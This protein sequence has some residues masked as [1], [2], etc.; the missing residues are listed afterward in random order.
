MLAASEVEAVRI[1]E[2]VFVLTEVLPFVIARARP[3]EALPTTLFVLAFTA[4]VIPDVCVFVFAFTL[5]TREVDAVAITLAVLA[6]IFAASE[7][8]AFVTSD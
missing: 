4:E 5:A 7:L 1:A 8:D 3:D 2:F 6:L